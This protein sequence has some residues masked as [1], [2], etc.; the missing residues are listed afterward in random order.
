MSKIMYSKDNIKFTQNWNNKLNNKAF[1]TI[2]L[3]NPN[4]YIIGRLYNIELKGVV[5][6]EAVL[7]NK[8]TLTMSQLNDFICYLDTGYNLGQ[9]ISILERMYS[10]INLKNASFDFCLLIYQRTE[11]QQNKPS[12]AQMNL[13]YKD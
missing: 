9:T 13:P 2:R 5:I 3:H 7:K 8:R 11:A 4:K 12:T 1:T 10:G 6:G